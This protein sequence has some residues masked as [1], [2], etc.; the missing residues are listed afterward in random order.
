MRAVE[1]DVEHG[2]EDLGPVL[3]AAADDAGAVDQHVE[4][5]QAARPAPARPACRG[6]RARRTSI[7]GAV[8]RCRRVGAARR[9]PRHRCRPCAMT[10]APC[11]ANA[12]AMP[13]PM[14]LVAPTTSTTRPAKASVPEA[15]AA[16]AVGPPR[17]DS[18]RGKRG[19]H[20][21]RIRDRR[22]GAE[23][24]RRERRRGAG[25]AARGFEVVT[26]ERGGRRSAPPK[27]S[28]APVASTGRHGCGAMRTRR[29][30]DR[31]PSAP[32]APSFSATTPAPSCQAAS[33]ASPPARRARDRA[34][35]SRLGKTDVAAGDR[36]ADRRR[37]PRRSATATG[38]GWSRT[39][40]S[41]RRRAPGDRS[42]RHGFACR[43]RDRRRDAR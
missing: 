16:V 15:A 41:R 10:C 22:D 24:R 2:G 28:P 25:V 17:S 37:A 13:A 3:V 12:A 11:A 7:V 33:R 27:V 42:A 9:R 4:R 23:A 29:V 6:R 43:G 32:S 26:G 5:R 21:R 38:A 34:R 30:A 36:L 14:P 19:S 31:R 20:L 8:A 40:P 39:T 1:V 18:P 35:S